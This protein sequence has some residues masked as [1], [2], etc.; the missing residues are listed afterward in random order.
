MLATLLNVILNRE[1]LR[2]PLYVLV[3]FLAIHANSHDD[4]RTY[5]ST[6]VIECF[7][8]SELPCAR[9]CN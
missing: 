4:I 5:L 9:L 3:V 1:V 6:F 8:I 2:Q 7:T